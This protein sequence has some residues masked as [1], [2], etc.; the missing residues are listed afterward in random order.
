L[1]NLR[2]IA[3]LFGPSFSFVLINFT[4]FLF[5]FCVFCAFKLF[6][7]VLIILRFLPFSSILIYF[8]IFAF[9]FAFTHFMR[10]SIFNLFVWFNHFVAFNLRRIAGVS[11]FFCA[12]QRPPPAPLVEGRGCGGDGWWRAPLPLALA[13][14][15]GLDEV[16]VLAAAVVGVVNTVAAPTPPSCATRLAPNSQRGTA[17][18]ESSIIDQF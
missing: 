18:Y 3:F 11:V 13:N 10:F 15:A 14:P 12:F 9:N 5:Q 6:R 2:R 7:L 4:N 17:K 1:F 16:E 8:H